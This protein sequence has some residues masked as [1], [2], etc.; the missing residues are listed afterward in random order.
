MAHG[1]ARDA[2]GGNVDHARAE[3]AVPGNVGI[4]REVV[5]GGAEARKIDGHETVF[6][7]EGIAGGERVA[8]IEDVV[9]ADGALV[10]DV[11]LVAGIEIVVAV[12]AGADDLRGAHHGHAA[13]IHAH[14]HVGGGEIVQEEG[15]H[16][17]AEHGGWDF[18]VGEGI[19]DDLRVAG[20]D[21]F[22]GIE[23]R[24]SAGAEGIVDDGAAHAEIAGDFSGRGNRF[25][26]RVC[27]G[28]SQAF[29]VGEEK[30][31]GVHDRAAEGRAEIV[32]DEKF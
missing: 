10:V 28:V 5:V 21:R 31:L 15:L 30:S 19:A 2:D 7:A 18:V 25:H 1:E 3:D 32:L 22:G 14:G 16:G 23:V 26:H 27:F 24:I 4:L 8:A 6:G 9:D 13:P 17:G 11:V 12:L 29:V 20:A